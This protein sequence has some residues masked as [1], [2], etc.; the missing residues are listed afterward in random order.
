MFLFADDG[1]CL[2][3]IRS[4]C[5]SDYIELQNNINA[6]NS[7]SESWQLPLAHQKYGVITFVPHAGP[8]I[9][10]YKLSEFVIIHLDVINDLGL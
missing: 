8:I 3:V 5:V 4:T 9:F 1:K 2:S 7:W 6:I 10:Q